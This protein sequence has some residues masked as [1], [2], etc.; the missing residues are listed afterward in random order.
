MALLSYEHPPINVTENRHVSN[1]V[2][3]FP[4]FSVM[5]KAMKLLEIS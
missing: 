1:I 2:L 3:G 5:P 4:Y